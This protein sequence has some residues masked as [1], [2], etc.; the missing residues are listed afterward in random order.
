MRPAM[1]TM[2]SSHEYLSSSPWST[3]DTHY[4]HCEIGTTDLQ[5]FNWSPT[6]VANPSLSE[7][8]C[9]VLEADDETFQREYGA[10][11]MRSGAF[12]FFDP[13]SIEQA[14]DSSLILP[15]EPR[16]GE[17][18]TAG[19]DFGFRSDFSALAVTHRMGSDYVVGELVET[20]PEPDL[21]LRPSHV[22]KVYAEVLKRHG[23]SALVADHH[24]RESVVEHLASHDI[25]FFDAPRQP[26]K[27]FIKLRTLLNQGRLR[28]P[29]QTTRLH[30]QL[31]RDMKAIQSRP[32]RG[33]G[34]SII[35]PRRQGGGHCD[36]VSALVLSV[37]PSKGH[38]FEVATSDAFIRMGKR[39]R[40]EIDKYVDELRKIKNPGIGDGPQYSEEEWIS[41]I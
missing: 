24:Y 25:G 32:T 14:L 20:R 37:W 1:A 27:S 9:R 18:T 29:D 39:E 26:D 21:P 15:R 12:T 31:V 3:L 5:Q 41:D 19:G 6:W 30:K 38:V 16:E 11:P 40:E 13:I 33:G 8:E 10:K 4:D 7:A 22:C 17:Q 35:L 23:I 34:L 28:L 36:L 2:P